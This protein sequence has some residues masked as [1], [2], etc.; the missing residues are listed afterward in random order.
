MA[1]RVNVQVDQAALARAIGKALGSRKARTLAQ[2]IANKE[3]QKVKRIAERI[4]REELHRRPDN[5]RTKSSLSHG[6]EYHDSFVVRQG[7][8]TGQTAAE[9]K[10]GNTHPAHA[11]IEKGSKGHPIPTGSKELIFPWDGAAIQKSGA[12]RKGSFPVA[13][14]EAPTRKEPVGVQHPGTDPHHIMDRA[15]REYA[16]KSKYN[17][18]VRNSD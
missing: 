2:V 3:G 5:R 13:Y 17:V 10:I 11:I 14:G 16:S 7:E 1:T 15:A 8:R 4:A 18:R 9:V 12:G 6:K